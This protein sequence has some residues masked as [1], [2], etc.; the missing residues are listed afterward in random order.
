MSKKTSFRFFV[1][2]GNR[3]SLTWSLTIQKND[4][5]VSHSGSGQDKISLHE[6]GSYQWSIR[7][8]HQASVPFAKDDRHI[9]KWNNPDAVP[10]TLT[11]QFF[12]LIAASE[13]QHERARPTKQATFLRAPPMAWAA[14]VDF[15]FFTPHT[16][17]HV[18]STTWEPKPI[19]EDRLAS[20][21]LLLVTHSQI[22]IDQ[23]TAIKFDAARAMGKAEGEKHGKD[24]SRALAKIQDP[25]GVWGMA[26]VLIKRPDS[27]EHPRT[28]GGTQ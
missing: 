15:V 11:R 5:Y 19:F 9:A 21:R 14:R 18:T 8:E 23:A 12:V 27:P 2:E 17:K 22:P 25:H 3:C 20:G 4:I 7:S 13:L 1:A 26:E 16:G 24:A 6:S 28:S 10:G